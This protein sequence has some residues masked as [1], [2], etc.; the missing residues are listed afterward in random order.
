MDRS[1]TWTTPSSRVHLAVIF[2][3]LF[4]DMTPLP[5][6]TKQKQNTDE[7]SLALPLRPRVHPPGPAGRGARQKTVRAHHADARSRRG[8]PSSFSWRC[9]CS[10]IVF[11][12]CFF[13]C[14]CWGSSSVG[15][16]R[17]PKTRVSSGYICFFISGF[18]IIR[19]DKCV[20]TP[21]TPHHSQEYCT[22]H[23]FVF[24]E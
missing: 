6:K 21:T 9:C 7:R 5:P 14:C 3:V 23:G 12:E 24:Q 4:M 2:F 11:A 1:T 15:E 18:F 8:A 10:T 20:A 13:F 19:S 17:K 16:R 22:K